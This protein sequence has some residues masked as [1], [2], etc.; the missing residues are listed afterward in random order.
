MLL[1]AAFIESWSTW[2]QYYETPLVTVRAA[3]VTTK[4]GKAG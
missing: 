3:L 2:L 1:F 4:P